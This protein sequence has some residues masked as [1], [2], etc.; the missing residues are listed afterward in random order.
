MGDAREIR[1]PV[2]WSGPL[3]RRDVLRF[4]G[5][6]VLGL[7]AAVLVGCGDDQAT[8]EF[9]ISPTATG[10]A[11]AS[12]TTLKDGA[13]AK[14][15][16]TAEV[17]NES[18]G[19]LPLG[20]DWQLELYDYPPPQDIRDGKH[21]TGR[22]YYQATGAIRYVG[23]SSVNTDRDKYLEYQTSFALVGGSPTEKNAAG[24]SMV[25]GLYLPGMSSPTAV[26]RWRED[27]P[28]WLV[29]Y[30]GGQNP[31]E[32]GR[33]RFGD[34][35]QKK[36]RLSPEIPTKTQGEPWDLPGIGQITFEGLRELR[37][38]RNDAYNIRAIFSAV[39]TQNPNDLAVRAYSVPLNGEFKLFANN[40]D[41]EEPRDPHGNFSSLRDL[42]PN[43]SDSKTMYIRPGE[44]AKR[45]EASIYEVGNMDGWTVVIGGIPP[46]HI[47]GL[48]RIA[49]A[50]YPQYGPEP[51]FAYWEVLPPGK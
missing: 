38:P 33:I 30:S 23:K 47:Q 45:F 6:A 17:K 24:P 46:E 16:P 41:K 49:L 14:L 8:P 28:E 9:Q 39:N 27:P 26:G 21:Y 35:T 25:Q 40:V 36:P 42:S 51:V 29:A 2:D 37:D 34:R 7:G 19:I 1:K 18:Q 3:T 50:F 22:K 11:S 20:P 48:D 43:P 12:G 44:P 32:I 15:D 13:F 4:G 31:R 5:T 10:T